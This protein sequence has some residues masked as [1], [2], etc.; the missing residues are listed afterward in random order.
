MSSRSGSRQNDKES[1]RVGPANSERWPLPVSPGPGRIELIDLN[2]A[3]MGIGM[4]VWGGGGVAVRGG[5]GWGS[6][7]RSWNWVM[8]AWGGASWSGWLTDRGS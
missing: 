3:P 2:R 4:A 6:R 7:R 8:S 5:A 1:I